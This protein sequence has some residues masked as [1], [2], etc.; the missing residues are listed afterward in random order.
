MGG[1]AVS[2]LCWLSLAAGDECLGHGVGL[3]VAPCSI[4]CRRGSA[5]TGCP[6]VAC[7][8]GEPEPWTPEKTLLYSLPAQSG[9]QEGGACLS[10]AGVKNAGHGETV[11]S[12]AES[13]AW[14]GWHV[15]AAGAL[16][17]STGAVS[18]LPCVPSPPVA[19][20]LN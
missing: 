7:F 6:V 13:L 12:L 14:K 11:L 1:S 15:W 9:H 20:T 17:M 4:H 5:S 19:T 18:L 10:L 2:Q 16:R 8:G 3:W